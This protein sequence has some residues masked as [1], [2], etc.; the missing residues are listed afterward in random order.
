[1]ADENG[2]QHGTPMRYLVSS[3]AS[4]RESVK[5][6]ERDVK[7]YGKSGAFL[8]KPMQQEIRQS[9]DDKKKED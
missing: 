8:P 3:S 1:M 2:G 6:S 7:T 9:K 4:A 5:Q